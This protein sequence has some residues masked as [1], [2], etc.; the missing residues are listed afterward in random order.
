MNP[1]IEAHEHP[2]GR[3]ILKYGGKETYFTN[4]PIS[5]VVQSQATLDSAQL[6]SRNS[7]MVSYHFVLDLIMITYFCC[8]HVLRRFLCFL[9]TASNKTTMNV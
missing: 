8:F 3:F 7:G 5:A 1:G 6:L 4:L 2:L 9:H